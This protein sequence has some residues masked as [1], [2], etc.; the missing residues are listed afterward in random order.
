MSLSGVVLSFVTALLALLTPGFTI[1]PAVQQLVVAFAPLAAMVSAAVYTLGRSRV[2][3]AAQG[4]T[5]AVAA[6]VASTQLRIDA[7][8]AVA[9]KAWDLAVLADDAAAPAKAKATAKRA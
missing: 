3:A 2:K 4:A 5:A 9:Q 8:T 1:P 6:A 7:D